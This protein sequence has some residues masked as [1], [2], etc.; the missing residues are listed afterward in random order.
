[1]VEKCAN[2]SLVLAELVRDQLQ[3]KPD[4]CLGLPTGRTPLGCY[5][6][7]SAWSKDSKVDWSQAR[8][9]QLDDYI[10]VQEEFS[11]HHY[12]EE[13]LYTFTNVNPKNT[14]NPRFI[15][16]Y[17]EQIAS[18]GGL[19]L[20]ILGIGRNG[21]IAFN[22]PGTPFRSWTHSM[23]LTKETREANSEFFPSPDEIPTRAVTMGIKTILNSRRLVLVASGSSKR[24]ILAKALHGPVTVDVPASFLQNHD[25]LLVLTDFD[26]NPE[27]LRAE[28]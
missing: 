17:D 22:E 14:F 16:D 23:F 12:L 7:L 21:H 9:F 27:K 28:S 24:D 6:L 10:D 3:A 13:H 26:I 18:L 2:L 19:D 11:F 25:N 20:T 8:C 5:Q 15:A 1:M 4:S